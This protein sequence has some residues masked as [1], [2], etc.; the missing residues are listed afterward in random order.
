MFDSEGVERDKFSVGDKIIFEADLY[1]Q[2]LNEHPRFGIAITSF[3]GTRIATLHTDVQ[4]NGKWVLEGNL[5]V[6]VEWNN[7]PLNVGIYQVDVSL[8]DFD[9]EHETLLGCKDLTIDPRDIYG[10][11]RL[12][13]PKYQD[14][15]VPDALWQI[16]IDRQ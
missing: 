9:R 4:Q 16:G 3:D 1:S 14:F 12:P 13:D 15:I 2:T 10:T 6:R 7:V 11:G 5:T 8:W